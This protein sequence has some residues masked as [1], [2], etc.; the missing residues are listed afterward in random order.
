M[1]LLPTV[2]AL[3]L[4]IPLAARAEEPWR[5]IT[6]ADWHM[7]EIYVQ[8]D[9]LLRQRYSNAEGRRSGDRGAGLGD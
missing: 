2:I 9:N 5:F 3:F 1:K 6:M 4:L 8:P 7:A